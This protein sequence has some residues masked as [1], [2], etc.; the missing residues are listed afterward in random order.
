MPQMQG[1]D[2]ATSRSSPARRWSTPTAFWSGRY[3]GK[4]LPGALDAGDEAVDFLGRRVDVEAGAVRR[5]DPELLHQRL[6]AMVTRANGDAFQV[7]HLRHVVRVDPGEVERHDS[8]ATLG[9]RPEQRHAG[10][11]GQPLERV[12]RE[13]VLVL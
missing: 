9:R 2:Q 1:N 10:D 5:R 3:S 6:A 7:E 4:Q 12:R 13:L 8:G 11:L